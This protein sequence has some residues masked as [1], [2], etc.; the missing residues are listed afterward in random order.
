MTFAFHAKFEYRFILD[1]A[2]FKIKYLLYY[3][4]QL[5]SCDTLADIRTVALKSIA[6][7][8]IDSYKCL[9]EYLV[10]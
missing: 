2:L 4:K 9:F 5:I 3:I 7:V 6:I 10:V 8:D 1:V